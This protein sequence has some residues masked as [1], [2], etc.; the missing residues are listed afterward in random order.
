MDAMA[1]SML[2][3]HYDLKN[4]YKKNIVLLKAVSCI[5]SKKTVGHRTSTWKHALN[6]AKPAM[7]QETAL[8]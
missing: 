6:M 1:L 7:K 3:Y 8:N 5:S 2:F 4:L